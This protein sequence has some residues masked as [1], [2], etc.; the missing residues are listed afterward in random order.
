MKAA[1][2]S[3]GIH[4][5]DWVCRHAIWHGSVIACYAMVAGVTLK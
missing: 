1:K 2:G 3:V 4:L 5:T